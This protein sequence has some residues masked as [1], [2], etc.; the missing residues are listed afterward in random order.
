M[1]HIFV[2]GTLKQ[3]MKNHHILNRMKAIYIAEVETTKTFPMFDL[4]NSF[5]YLQDK[6]GIGSIIQGQ[7]FMIDDEYEKDLDYFEGVPTLYKKGKI[8]IEVENLKYSDI[9]C[10]FI[11]D[12]LSDDEL[13]AVDFLEDWQD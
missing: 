13:N 6:P 7:L 8:D 12:E 4:G 3:G 5:P 2:Y 11:S 10:Y 9:N 1:K